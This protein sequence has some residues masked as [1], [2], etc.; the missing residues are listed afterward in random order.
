[1]ELTGTFFLNYLIQNETEIF[2][3]IILSES[4]K[5]RERAQGTRE[6]MDEISDIAKS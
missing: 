4:L 3:I 5:V 6:K 1:M 2:R